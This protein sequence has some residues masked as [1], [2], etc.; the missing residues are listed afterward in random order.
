MKDSK[1]G[2]LHVLLVLVAI[3]LLGYVAL[4]GVG[5]QHRGTAK[6]IKLGLDLA[7]GVSITYETVKTNPTSEE[8]SDTI[9]KMQKR[10][11]TYS[12]ESAVYQEGTNRITIDIPGEQDADAVLESLGK[13]GAL[14]FVEDDAMNADGTYEKAVLTGS[15]V[16]NAQAVRDQDP[17]T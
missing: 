17:T 3:A 11:E 7:G 16:K 2:L 5:K 15:H 4:V 1:K 13:A 10:A 12:T 9:N 14:E 6:N 8:M